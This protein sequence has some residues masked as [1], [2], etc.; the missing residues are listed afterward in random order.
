MRYA[1]RHRESNRLPLILFGLLFLDAFVIVIPSMLLVAGAIT[2]TPRRWALFC[3]LFILAVLCN[4]T[5]TYFL[6]LHLPQKVIVSAVDF[7]NL[8]ILWESALQGI[9]DYGKYVT[10]VGGFLPLPTQLVTMII[11]MAEAQSIQLGRHVARPSIIE[12]LLFAGLG[13]GIKIFIFGWLVRS[14]WV[15]LEKRV[16]TKEPELLKTPTNSK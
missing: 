3:S 6:G 1:R 8:R 9:I 4:N 12:A 16:A 5:T 13:H 7:M 10:F 15:K 2:I 11:G 14:G